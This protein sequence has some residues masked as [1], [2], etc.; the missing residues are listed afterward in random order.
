MKR[1][2]DS[3]WAF[4]SFIIAKKNGTVRFLTDFRKVNKMLV[5]KPWPLPKISTVLQELEKSMW[6]S[7]LDL[8]I[9]YYHI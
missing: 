6:A 4:P 1:E 9:G 2:S 5:Q 8:N 7:S 3:E